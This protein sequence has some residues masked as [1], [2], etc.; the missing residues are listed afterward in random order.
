MFVFNLSYQSFLKEQL[1][2][3]NTKGIDF[4]VNAKINIILVINK[5]VNF[6]GCP[7]IQSAAVVSSETSEEVFTYTC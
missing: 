6:A 2:I 3:D 7:L 4:N 1:N 5:S